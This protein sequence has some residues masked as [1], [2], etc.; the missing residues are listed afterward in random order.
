MRKLKPRRVCD[1]TDCRDCFEAAFLHALS[2]T[3]D[4]VL[5]SSFL[6]DAGHY[7]LDQRKCGGRGEWSASHTRLLA[8]VSA[9]RTHGA[10]CLVVRYEDLA[11]DPQRAAARISAWMP[12]LGRLDPRLAPRTT[13]GDGWKQIVHCDEPSCGG[14]SRS[15]VRFFQEVPLRVTC[16]RL[17][18]RW[19]AT[20]RAFGYV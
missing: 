13:E 16:R 3:T 8:D 7:P 14:R 4:R 19:R 20:A 12:A 18:P 11:T 1:C 6:A 10:L 15:I 17:P 5:S 2:F 9:A